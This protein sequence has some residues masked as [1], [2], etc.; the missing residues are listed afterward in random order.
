MRQ[1][2]LFI[3][4]GFFYIG[5]YQKRLYYYDIPLG[6]LQLSSFLKESANIK[7]QII[8]LRLEGEKNKTLAVNS[9][10]DNSFKSSFI[11]ILEHSG[12][13]DF[14]TIGINCYTS[15]HFHQSNYIGNIIKDE[16]P[17]KK[18]VVGG[19]HPTAVPE[20]FS[21][22]DSPFNYIIKGEAEYP[23]LELISSKKLEKADKKDTPEIITAKKLVDLNSLPLPDY[24]LYLNQYPLNDTLKFEFYMSRGCPYQCAFCA[25][26]YEFR[27]LSFDVFK[28][29]FDQLCNI[30]ENYNKNLL[31]IGFADQSFNRVVI[32]EKV[33]DYI[34]QN[35]L[36]DRF[37]FSCQSRVENLS[38]RMDL[39]DKYRKS[40][41]I[42]GYGFETAN[43]VLLREMHKTENP[44][45]YINT[46]EQI[47]SKY[48]EE[49]G[50]YC[51]INLLAGF[52]GENQSS[53]NETVD[54]VEKNALDTNIQISPTLFSNYP[55]VYVYR[56]MDYYRNKFGA[57]FIEEWWKLR[58]NP[59]LN[60]IPEKPST[61]YTKKQLIG[62]YKDKYVSILKEFKHDTFAD[63]VK[64]K[65]FF[66]DL[67]KSL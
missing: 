33:L 53:F 1:N 42:V 13:Q 20:D 62:D 61:N 14:Q 12:I 51:R 30:V 54:F 64:W 60:S 17:S 19:Y 21:Y 7:T 38:N 3:I 57:E 45:N 23:M 44:H 2:I 47:I 15:Y 39:I 22:K 43:D 65:S 16:F 67:Y 32:S 37:V 25:S 66:N 29:H 50:T 55:N 49:D 48:K 10:D 58:L 28:K 8:D 40:N 4:P 52:P 26:N 63:I 27:S 36:Q 24:D 11:K 59:L 31:K 46:M 18:I 6:T 56:N 5:D 34:I 35:E 9:P 41:M